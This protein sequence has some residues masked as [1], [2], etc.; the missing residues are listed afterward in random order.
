MWLA[1]RVPLAGAPE[2]PIVQAMLALGVGAGP[3]AALMMTLPPVSLLSL[4]RTGKV[5]SIRVLAMIS[6]VV[7]VMGI[8]HDAGQIDAAGWSRPSVLTRTA[9]RRGACAIRFGCF[10]HLDRALRELMY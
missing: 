2:V 5:L 4:T 6:L 3:A 1:G 8:V 9:A 7:L 10:L